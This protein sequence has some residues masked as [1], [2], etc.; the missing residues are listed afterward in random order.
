MDDMNDAKVDIYRDV[1]S[2]DIYCPQ[3]N[4]TEKLP[5]IFYVH[6][7]AWHLGDKSRA[8]APC[9]DLCKEG[10]ICVATSYGLSCASNTQIEFM[11]GLIIVFLTG[12]ALVAK[13][14]AQML[15]IFIFLVVVVSF[16]VVLWAFLPRPHVE[17]PDHIL[18][19]ARNFKWVLE[20]ISEYGGD[21]NRIVV[22]GHSA[23]GHLASLL[24]TNS[25]YLEQLGVP[26]K[27]IRACISV[28]GVYS[29]VRLKET[30]IGRQLLQNAFGYR[31]QFYDAFPIY[32]V[33]EKTPPF[34]LLNAGMDITLKRH[35]FDFH[36]VLRQSGAYVETAYFDD[37]SHWNIMEKWGTKN[38]NI[39][40]KVQ[41]FL[42]AIEL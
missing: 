3:K 26:T 1:G 29:D 23:G 34:L 31:Q 37:K 2:V 41:E 39:L 21:P 32:H 33:T 27:S 7:G 22:M 12:L 40:D 6:G 10:Y 28:S 13:S 17:H 25:T 24:S 4:D 11:L 42:R 35:S 38:R 36:Y 19:V 20:N 5:V 18:D 14:V 15:L 9:E 30:S 16:L 8:V